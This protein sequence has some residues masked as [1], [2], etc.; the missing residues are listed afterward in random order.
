MIILIVKL[1]WT[2]IKIGN[3]VM[4]APTAVLLGDVELEDGVSVF[5]N[6]VLRGDLNRIRIGKNSNIQDNVT[7]H[8]ERENSVIVGKNVSAINAISSPLLFTVAG[9]PAMMEL[10]GQVKFSFTTAP[11]PTMHP[12]AMYDPLRITDPIPIITLSSTLAP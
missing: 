2:M 1:S 4:L 3:N 5:D 8:T 9:I 10:M 7:I 6:A 12:E 11:A